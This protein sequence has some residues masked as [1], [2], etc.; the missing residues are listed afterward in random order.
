VRKEYLAKI[1]NL[2]NRHGAGPNAVAS[3][4][5]RPCSHCT[6]ARFTILV[7]CSDELAVH[8][9]PLVFLQRLVGKPASGL[10]HRWSLLRND[11]MATNLHR[12]TSNNGRR[13]VLPHV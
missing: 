5:G 3:A 10:Y 8:W 1:N 6:E 13:G 2:P 4:S 12:F 11:D 9:C 7:S